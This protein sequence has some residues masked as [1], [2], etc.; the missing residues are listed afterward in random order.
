MSILN[1]PRINF[2]GVFHT[3]PCTANNDDVMP[4]VVVRDQNI[5]GKDLEGKTDEEIREY[6]REKVVM[7]NYGDDLTKEHDPR[8]INFIRSGWNLYGDHFTSFQD[9]K[10]TSI[11]LGEGR[12][13]RISS[14]DQDELI[15]MPFKVLGSVTNDPLRRGDPILCD[16]DPTGLVTTQLFVGGIQFGSGGPSGVDPSQIALQ[17]NHDTR[18]FQDWLNFNSTVGDYGGEQNFVGIGCIMQFTIPVS[19]FPDSISSNSTGLGKLM[20]S[21]SAAAGIAIRFRCYE[22][23][24]SITD[25]DLGKVF[26]QG[27]AV[28]N[29]A[30]G[31][32]VGTIGVWEDG[33]PETEPAG[34]K[35]QCHYPRPQMDWKS[36]DGK[37]SGSLPPANQPWEGP[38]SLIG[39]VVALVRQ[40]PSVISLDI[41]ESF[42]KY[43]FRDPD[44]PKDGKT[45]FNAPKEKANVG[46][47][48]L[49][50]IPAGGGD[51][52][53][54]A[55]IDYGLDNFGSY[56][57][58]GGIQDF[59]F[60]PSQYDAISKGTLVLRGKNTSDINAN[61]TLVKEVT[62]RVVTDDRTAYLFPNTKNHPFR[63]KVYERGGPT[64]KDITLFLKEYANI[65]QVDEST[66]FC[67]NGH[68]PNQSVSARK[69]DKLVVPASVT[70]PAGEGYNDWFE[71]NVSTNGSGATILSY[72]L[73]DIVFGTTNGEVGP[74]GVPNWSTAN[75]SSI[76]VFTDDNF[77][78]IYA[79][80]EIKWEDV[81]ENV[82]RYYYVLFP[83][84]SRIIPLN[85]PDSIVGKGDLIKQRLH[86]PDNPA[87]YSTYNMPVTRTMSPNKV[88]LVLD[89]IEQE[90]KKARA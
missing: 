64:T 67:E 44:G 36:K 62:T 18:G 70:I 40:S 15:D 11:V 54:I 45:N 57:N 43:G 2:R 42:P 56:E 47:V 7:A 87:F 26:E 10:I 23:Q 60:D 50:Y 6:L 12:E 52:V 21:A 9:T 79:Q 22:V 19:A 85:L 38:P 66:P 32:L 75:Y 20:E 53:H 5:L 1:F 72:Q 77:S 84:M 30:L 17:I 55:D 65:I 83:A 82:L 37:E 68:R 8:C 29:P 63:I 74:A 3:N 86:T 58:F 24:P 73:K 49:A 90:Q 46:Q 25:G 88:K 78:D 4:D 69:E 80:N 39:N 16:L 51:P 89:F 33:E 81:Y 34:R 61:V 35:L 59:T 71:I 28:E 14:K 31:Y 41:V 27:N 48:E 76:R 13:N